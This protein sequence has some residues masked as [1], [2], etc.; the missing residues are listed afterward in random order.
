MVDL[1]QQDLD[2]LDLDFELDKDL[3]FDLDI[4][5]RDVILDL[6]LNRD[7]VDVNNMPEVTILD[8]DLNLDLD[9]VIFLYLE[10][11][12]D[13]RVD[14]GGN[15][16]YNSTPQPDL[17]PDLKLFRSVS[18]TTRSIVSDSRLKCTLG[19]TSKGMFSLSKPN[20][21]ASQMTDFD[22]DIQSIDLLGNEFE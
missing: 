16:D 15:N 22:D 5:L 11:D 19:S 9:V 18:A 13:V 10:L 14:V 6:D 2:S 3:D 12:L 20:R 1:G 4:D 8:C 21:V 17:I 7:S